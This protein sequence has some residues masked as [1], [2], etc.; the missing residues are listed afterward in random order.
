[1]REQSLIKSGDLL[2]REIVARHGS[3]LAN[4]LAQFQE[5]HDRR[6]LHAPNAGQRFAISLAGV[7]PKPLVQMAGRKCAPHA[8]RETELL[9]EQDGLEFELGDDYFRN[10]TE[11]LPH[12]D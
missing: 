9:E 12:L 11:W 8:T 3:K 7:A 5:S 6:S 2:G 1:M 10:R 4:F